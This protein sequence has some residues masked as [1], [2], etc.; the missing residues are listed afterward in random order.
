MFADLHIELIG[1]K[2][3]RHRRIRIPGLFI[4]ILVSLAILLLLST[5]LTLVSTPSSQITINP[6]PDKD[7][8]RIAKAI[9]RKL[10]VSIEENIKSSSTLSQLNQELLNISAIGLGNTTHTLGPIPSNFS[11]VHKS[12]FSSSYLDLVSTKALCRLQPSA[13]VT[14]KYEHVARMKQEIQ[15]EI[16]SLTQHKA[17]IVALNLKR[18]STPSLM[19]AQG[20]ITSDYGRR[21]DPFTNKWTSHD[22]IDIAAPS[23]TE[24]LAPADGVVSYRGS[25]GGYGNLIE[26][27]HPDGTFTRYGHL[28]QSFV[29]VGQ[30]VSRGSTI[31]LVG[32]SGRSTG[33]HLHYEVRKDKHTVD[34]KRYLG[35]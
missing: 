33:P 31:G 12:G 27:K 29:Q 16:D 15:N 21:K 7:S 9:E 4:V 20:V 26:L 28:L 25:A 13:C 6:N 1:P 8:S 2:L 30:K 11:S 18:A 19:P 22:G 17:S 5:T 34:P 23:G 35:F 10:G 32:S 24:V 14:Q 3:A